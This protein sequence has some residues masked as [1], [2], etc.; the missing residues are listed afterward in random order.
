MSCEEINEAVW[1]EVV[2]YGAGPY[3]YWLDEASR[4]DLAALLEVVVAAM[5]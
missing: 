5:G 4:G 3:N 2:V 1:T